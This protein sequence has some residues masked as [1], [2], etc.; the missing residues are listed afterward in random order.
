MQYACYFSLNETKLNV[1][2]ILVK[3]YNKKFHENLF[4]EG[5]DVSFR[6]T[7]AE[8]RKEEPV[9]VT[10]AVV[11]VGGIIIHLLCKV[12]LSDR[13]TVTLQLRVSLSDR[14]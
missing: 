1:T 2:D 5:Q 3:T 13:A 7:G 4:S 12:T 11:S 9:Q 6:P 10:G 8:E 14:V